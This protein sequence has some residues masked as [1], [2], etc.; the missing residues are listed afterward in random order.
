MRRI[1]L[2]DYDVEIDIPD[3]KVKTTPYLVKKSLVNM[4]YSQDIQLTARDLL[5]NDRVAQKIAGSN[6]VVL[7]EEEEYVRVKHA[8]ESLRGLS[9][10]DVQL[11][12]RV[13]D[14]PQVEVKEN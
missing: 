7:L 1:D 10:Q 3:D 12:K 4:M 2:S 6:G 14:A 8:L 13:F 9:K 11:V 5:D